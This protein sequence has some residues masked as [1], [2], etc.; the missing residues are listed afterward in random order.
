MPKAFESYPLRRKVKNM[1]VWVLSE[2]S[3]KMKYSFGALP[4][5]AAEAEP[6]LGNQQLHIHR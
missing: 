4:Y 1:N 2:L 6:H 3:K 5:L